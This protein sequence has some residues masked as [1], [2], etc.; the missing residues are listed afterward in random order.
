MHK[1]KKPTLRHGSRG[2]KKRQV[3]W[4]GS[5]I[6]EKSLNRPGREA[7]GGHKEEMYQKKKFWMLSECLTSF[8]A[9]GR[10]RYEPYALQSDSLVKQYYHVC[11]KVFQ[12][13]FSKKKD[14]KSFL[15]L[16]YNSS[17]TRVNLVYAQPTAQ[18]CFR[19]LTWHLAGLSEDRGQTIYQHSGGY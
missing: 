7:K 14:R 18:V 17:G 19:W 4:L 9:T 13:D 10:L 3:H 5:G 16:I 8:R 2:K 11:I 6:R 12:Q 1:K 15:P